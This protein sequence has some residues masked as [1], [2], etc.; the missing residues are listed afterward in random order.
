MT[1]KSE[2]GPEYKPV[3][4]SVTLT[5]SSDGETRHTRPHVAE[6]L[7]TPNYAP[8]QQGASTSTALLF[9]DLTST[10][11]IVNPDLLDTSTT[12]FH[13]EVACISSAVQAGEVASTSSVM[14]P[15][16]PRI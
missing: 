12:V 2:G 7:E 9:G 10:S 14:Q 16:P 11:S 6:V 15:Q 3:E 8:L 13:G 1:D 5:A 4:S